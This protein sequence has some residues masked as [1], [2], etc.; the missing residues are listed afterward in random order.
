MRGV[1]RRG[2]MLRPANTLFGALPAFAMPAPPPALRHSGVGFGADCN[3][4]QLAVV[5]PAGLV[6]QRETDVGFIGYCAASSM[7]TPCRLVI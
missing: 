1:L 3:V 4:D 7:D 5:L 2:P 6:Q